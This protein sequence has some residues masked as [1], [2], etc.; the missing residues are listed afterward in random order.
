MRNLNIS[1]GTAQKM[2]DTKKVYQQNRPI[3]D[4]K[5]TVKGKIEILLFE[6][7]SKGLKPIF[8]T[9]DFA[10]FDKPSGVIVHPR[11]RNTS[12]S[13]L[14]EARKHLGSEANVI[15]RIDLETSGLLLVSTHKKAEKFLK[16]S[17]EAKNVKKG[18][19][20]LTRGKIE[21]ELFIDEPIK[22]N[23]DFSTIRLKVLI[24]HDGKPAQTIIK[25]LKYFPKIDA[26]LVEA[27]PLTG[28]QH[29][30]RA[31]LFHVKHPIVGDPIYGVET[32]IAIKYLDRKLSG[33]ERIKYTGAKRLLLHANWIEFNYNKTKYKIFSKYD[34]L[35]EVE[36]LSKLEIKTQG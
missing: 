27:L 1:Q 36:N 29:Q 26:T 15:H 31:H 34:F 3:T 10:I 22:K 13:I 21:N 11:N 16:Q 35:S 12:Y 20:A 18:Y 8:K 17:F 25:P 4:K 28:R 14:D 32:E 6:P 7:T 24:H 33:K 30:I 19:L 5:A 23:R 2:I 9:K